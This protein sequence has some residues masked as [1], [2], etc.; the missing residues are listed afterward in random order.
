MYIFLHNAT[1][2][3]LFLRSFYGKAF[4]DASVLMNKQDKPHAFLFVNLITTRRLVVHRRK[5]MSQTLSQLKEELLHPT[6][7]LEEILL[8]FFTVADQSLN[9]ILAREPNTK[10]YLVKRTNWNANFFDELF[11]DLFV[12]LEI[13]YLMPPITL[14]IKV[15]A[16]GREF[17]QEFSDSRIT[18]PEELNG[19]TVQ[20]F[21][22]VFINK[23]GDDV[24][25]VYNK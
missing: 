19:N 21:V 15:Y 5:A 22:D 11:S 24:I 20:E 8:V 12:R 16:D 14:R 25:R 7:D 9:E 1:A 23:L 18:I 17:Y 2:W 4:G 3:V 6:K 13:D 10:I